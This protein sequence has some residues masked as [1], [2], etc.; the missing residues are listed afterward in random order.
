[1]SLA[2][3]L[4]FTVYR[5]T[6]VSAVVSLPIYLLFTLYRDTTASITALFNDL[7]N[8][9]GEDK[10]SVLLLLDLSATFDTIDHQ[11]LLSRLETV[12][13][14]RSTA[15]QWFQSYLLGRSQ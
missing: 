10:I 12:F 5:D 1:M 11:I 6:T 7:L 3:Y 13:G 9:M 14:I 4:L 2:I 8:A 15:L